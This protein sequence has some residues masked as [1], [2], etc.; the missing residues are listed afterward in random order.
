MIFSHYAQIFVITHQAQVASQGDHQLHVYKE[1]YQDETISIVQYLDDNQR[2]QEIARIIGGVKITSQTLA[3]ASEMYQNTSKVLICYRITKVL[4]MKKN[5]DIIDIRLDK[6]LWAAR[7]FKT[8]QLAKT[9]INQ[10]KVQYN[11][12]KAKVSRKVEKQALLSIKLG[13]VEKE[14]IILDISDIRGPYSIVRHLYKE[15]QAS[16][17][18]NK[19]RLELLSMEP[20]IQNGKLTKKQR[21]LVISFKSS[22]TS[23]D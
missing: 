21:R 3:H 9:A 18:K 5:T 8:R 20:K 10:G 16:I 2:I 11:G 15:T 17:R 4:I 19:E 6:W 22:Y 13:S 1:H 7:F 23:N 14:V 12:S